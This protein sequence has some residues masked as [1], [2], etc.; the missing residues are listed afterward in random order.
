MLIHL[1]KLQQER[2]MSLRTIDPPQPR[3]GDVARYL[4]LLGEGEEAVGL[5]AEDE[6]GLCD[7]GQRCADGG[8]AGAGDVVGVELA[9]DGDVA[10]WVEAGDEFGALVA[11]VGLCGV[12]V[13][14]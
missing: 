12:V 1:L 3:M 8:A 11:Q 10:V 9:G 2:I 5:D 14:S 13:G 7:L 4:L 6:A